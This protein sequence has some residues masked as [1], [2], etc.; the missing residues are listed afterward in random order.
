MK[1]S[2]EANKLAKWL[3][4][5]SVAKTIY[6]REREQLWDSFTKILS[7]DED[8]EISTQLFN[9]LKSFLVSRND[10]LTD[11]KELAFITAIEQLTSILEEFNEEDSV[12]SDSEEKPLE[13]PLKKKKSSIPA[14]PKL[15]KI[16]I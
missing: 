4:S 12:A 7:R 5:A 15:E 8:I 11:D 14:A 9:S 6:H 10:R 2:I 3:D 16:E 1:R 13:E